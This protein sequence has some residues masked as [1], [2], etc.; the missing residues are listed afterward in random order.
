MFDS[1]NGRV[2]RRYR[3]PHPGLVE[4]E[5]VAMRH[6]RAHGA[7]VPEVYSA[8]GDEIV[9]E[10][11]HGR[12]LMDVLTS[13]PWRA[14]AIGRQLAE[15]QRRIH[16]VPVGA[17]DLPR[18]SAGNS[19]LHFDLH[20][21]NVM[22]TDSGPVVID[23]SNVAIGDP[24][25]D[26]MFSWMLMTTGEPDSVPFLLRPVTRL[27]RQRL[28]AGFIEGTAIDDQAAA[29]VS[30]TCDRRLADPNTTEVEKR[31]IHTFAARM[32]MPRAC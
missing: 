29:W 32:S 9:M 25:A 21:D 6:L 7:P 1:G 10:R 31:N 26:V 22:L 20:P 27:V 16:E 15:V 18:F 4:R 23:W 2:V 8:S 17:L 12:S 30:V 5:A 11:I 3:T 24:L 28:V 13:Q 19:I 14:A